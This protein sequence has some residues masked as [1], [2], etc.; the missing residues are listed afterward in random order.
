MLNL[1]QVATVFAVCDQLLLTTWSQINAENY[2]TIVKKTLRLA[3]RL[4]D[5]Q[6][7]GLCLNS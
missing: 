3:G 2:K 6:E 5:E 4:A 1:L 7:K